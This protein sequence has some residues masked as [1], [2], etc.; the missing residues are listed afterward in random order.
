MVERVVLGVG[1]LDGMT[2]EQR[3]ADHG[4]GSWS[5]HGPPLARFVFGRDALPRRPTILIS[6][7]AE[8]DG[9]IGSAQSMG[10]RDDGLQHRIEVKARATD[11]LQ[12]FGGRGLPLQPL[13]TLSLERGKLTFEIGYTL[14]G[15]GKRVV[16]RR[17]HC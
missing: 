5:D 17:V 6:L 12:D 7:L 1:D 14:L 11:H 10:G 16:G 13:I 9:V 15:I 8:D 4:V 3:A 2:G